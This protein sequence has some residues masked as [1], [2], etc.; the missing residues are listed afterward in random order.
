MIKN[1]VLD[2]NIL[3]H[4]PNCIYKFEENNIYIPH[5]VLEEL[6]AHKKDKGERGYSVR[7]ALRNIKKLRSYGKLSNG[8]LVTESGKLYTYVAED[9]SAITLPFGWKRDNMDNI[10]LMSVI[11]LSKKVENVKLVTNDADMQLKADALGIEVEEYKNDRLTGD[12]LLYAGKSIRYVDNE[13]INKF[14]ADGKVKI[15]QN[16]AMMDLTENEYVCL[17]TAENSSALAKTENG[18]FRKLFYYNSS[19]S[20]IEARNISQRFLMESLMTSYE[21]VPLTVCNGPAGTGKTLLALAVGLEKVIEHHEYKSVLICR[22]NVTMENDGMGLGFLPGTEREKIDPLLRG[23]YDALEVIYGNKY[24][25]REEMQSKVYYLFD[26]GY[27]E[28]Q[29]IA[30]LRG[31]SITNRYIIID[32]AQNCTPNQMLSIITRVGEGSKIVLLGDVNQVDNIR[33]DTRNNG[34]V[35]VIEKMKGSNLCDIITFDE[36]E[37][38]RSELAKEASKRLKV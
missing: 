9:T 30:Y 31:R 8:V 13:L 25:T 10:I 3:I 24:D 5:P 32:E 22:A 16:D 23:A 26:K 14:F 38:R 21:S 15:P 27:I 19:P 35:Y 20:D 2:T 29:S 4:D 36:S 7:E 37:C 12:N 18:F 28:A 17:K 11:E 6:D 1:F 34:L 33:L